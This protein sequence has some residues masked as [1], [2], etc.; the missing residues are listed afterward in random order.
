MLESISEII[1]GKKVA[2]VDF[3]T[4]RIGVAYCDALHIS[5]NTLETLD[6]THEHFIDKFLKLMQSLDI[7]II[8]LGVPYW[9][10]SNKQFSK[11]LNKF[12]QELSEKHDFYVF[13]QDESF[14]SKRASQI[15]IEIGK[16]RY[17]RRHK[18][19]TDKISAAIILR[20]F[21]NEHGSVS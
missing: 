21:L 16:K 6:Y 7:Q 13:K 2:A 8:V 9:N 20:D 17:T 12:I 1:K 19:Q 11:K 15:M 4:K 5:I 18:G 3:G 10:K 14:S